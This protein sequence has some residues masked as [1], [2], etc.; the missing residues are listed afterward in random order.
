MPTK[1]EVLA[2]LGRDDLLICLDHVGLQVR[3]RR[4]KDDLVEAL[5]AS[6]KARIDEILALLSREALKAATPNGVDIYFDNVGGEILDTV[7]A[8]MNPFSRLPLCGLI[9]Q[10]NASEAYGVK[11]FRSVLTNR[12]RVQGFI[13][14]DD[15]DKM[16][17]ALTELAQWVAEGR[18]RWRETIAEGLRSAPEAF[19]GMLRGHNVGKQLVKLF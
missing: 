6:K 7:L 17:V 10:Y 13:V 18:L 4:V 9:S 8:R 2:V 19:I 5:A 12:I 1:R 11:N 15:L 3:D 16:R 14:F